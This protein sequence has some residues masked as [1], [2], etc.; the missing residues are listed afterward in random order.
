[1]K[2]SKCVQ[3]VLITAALASCGR[4]EKEWTSENKVYMRSD[5]T[6]PYSHAR[7]HGISPLWF[8]AFRPFGSYSNGVY[9]RG[10][11]YSSAL[12]QRSNFGSNATKAG[13]SRGGF[14]RSGYSVSS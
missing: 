2:K 14:G 8:F 13:I 10:G 12:S 11:Y 7:H 4:E 6:A 5:T 1:M 9:Q 3:L